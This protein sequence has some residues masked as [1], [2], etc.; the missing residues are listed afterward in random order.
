MRRSSN[1]PSRFLRELPEDAIR[2]I[3]AW[4][5]ERA[6][7]AS[8]FGD[9]AAPIPR[10]ASTVEEPTIDYSMSQEE[11]SA[12]S[13]AVGT[14]VVH[15]MFGPGIVRR[16][17]GSGP[18]TKLTVQFERAGLKKLIARVAPLTVVDSDSAW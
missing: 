4:T 11:G 1:P 2:Q 15:P 3:G 9:H 5:E 16:R 6:V 13:L 8:R 17:E 12:S 14:R 7:A 10:V 18:A